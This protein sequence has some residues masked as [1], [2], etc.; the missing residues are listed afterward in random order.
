MKE[1]IMNLIMLTKNKHVIN[2]YSKNPKFFNYAIICG[3]GVLIQSIILMF[4]S[5]SMPLL[6]ANFIGVLVAWLWNYENSVGRFGGE[7][8]MN[9]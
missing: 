7:W 9:D 3:I 2:A 5:N 1:A 6:L 8:G 4:L